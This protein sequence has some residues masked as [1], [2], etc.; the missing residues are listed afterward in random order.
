MEFPRISMG[1]M[2]RLFD[3]YQLTADERWQFRQV[4]QQMDN[5]YIEAQREAFEIKRKRDKGS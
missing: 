5:M 4:V 1:N 3:E 2:F